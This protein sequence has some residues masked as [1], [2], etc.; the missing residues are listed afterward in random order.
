[1]TQEIHKKGRYKASFKAEVALEAIRGEKTTQQLASMYKVSPVQVEQ[2][3]KQAMEGVSDAFRNSPERKPEARIE[4]ISRALRKRE[5][6]LEWLIK[7][8]GELGSADDRRRLVDDQS[9]ITRKRQCELLNI[10]R[11][12]SYYKRRERSDEKELR[13]AINALYKE[14]PCLGVRRLAVMVSQRIGERVGVKKIRRV[15]RE[16]GLETICRHKYPKKIVG[17][18]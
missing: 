15:R 1:M 5:I 2:W 7:K 16:M 4:S 14:D 11:S 8:S 10:S 9:E 17:G 6:E 12:T 3:A 13:E 18:A